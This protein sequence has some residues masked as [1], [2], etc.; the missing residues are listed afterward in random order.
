MSS[1]ATT[2]PRR[3]TYNDRAQ[4]YVLQH[5][6]GL[7]LCLL[8]FG[9]RVLFSLRCR[10]GVAQLHR[11]HEDVVDKFLKP[12]A[13][14]NTDTMAK[15][16]LNIMWIKLAVTMRLAP[17]SSV[18]A[19]G[20]EICKQVLGFLEAPPPKKARECWDQVNVLKRAVPLLTAVNLDVPTANVAQ[21]YGGLSEPESL[22]Q[23]GLVSRA[24]L[25]AVLFPGPE[26]CAKNEVTPVAV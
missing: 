7:S 25:W 4:Q 12:H 13:R 5:G 22:E 6:G 2:S 3:F 14:K 11:A 15:S 17:W 26:E 18:D 20:V 1:P 10:E 19:G 8:P 9:H 21:V 23:L 24:T 16:A